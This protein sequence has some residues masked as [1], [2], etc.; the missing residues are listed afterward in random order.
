M[1]GISYKFI[2]SIP[3]KIFKEIDNN[4]FEVHIIG[5]KYPLSWHSCHIPLKF[6][7]DFYSCLIEFK[8]NG[9]LKFKFL[10][11]TINRSGDEIHFIE[12]ITREL[13]L[14]KNNECIFVFSEKY[15]RFNFSE[16]YS[17][18]ACQ[19]LYYSPIITSDG[20]ITFCCKDFNA[21]ANIGNISEKSLKELWNS[22]KMEEYRLRHIRGDFSITPFCSN[23]T[24]PVPANN[25]TILNFL[26]KYGL[27]SIFPE[28]IKRSNKEFYFPLYIQIELTDICQLSCNFCNQI[29][30]SPNIHGNSCRGYL[31]ADDANRI[32]SELSSLGFPIKLLSLFWMGEP[33]LNP[34]ILKILKLLKK[35][36]NAHS[37]Y[38]KCELHTNAIAF[39]PEF[40]EI[41]LK[42]A[43]PDMRIL[44]SIDAASKD[45]YRKIKNG[46]FNIVMENIKHYIDNFSNYDIQS[47]FQFI[48][49]PENFCEYKEFY[50]IFSNLLRE[51]DYQVTAWH[52]W[53][54]KFII[55]F[56]YCDPLVNDN[57][58]NESL[59]KVV[60]EWI[61]TLSEHRIFFIPEYEPRECVLP[62]KG[63]KYPCA[64]CFENPTI[65]WDGEVTTCCHDIDMKNSLG[66]I[67]KDGFKNIW[68][69]EKINELR[70][71][72]LTGVDIKN[73]ACHDCSFRDSSNTHHLNEYYLFKLLKRLNMENIILEY[74]MYKAG[75]NR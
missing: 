60:T 35:Y 22:P 1:K 48:V 43:P 67:L 70:K 58:M 3:D 57:R 37:F 63:F 44:F 45:T 5:N 50:E 32:F 24:E 41:F 53:I 71:N 65:R 59:Y 29:H 66:N 13:S 33:L 31:K 30:K 17:N 2:L 47:I 26:K 8:D 15:F 46:D 25:D 19:N 34:D 36:Q 42:N 21:E 39:T 20:N 51:Y 9:I 4:L 6:E 40:Q 69:G 64:S 61:K 14:S 12:S 16:L 52:D 54:K 23:C 72:M 73:G 38:Q 49:T 74:L 18:K 75:K 68:F 11:S 27:S 10:I 62:S 7:N 28:Y 55:Y 56:K